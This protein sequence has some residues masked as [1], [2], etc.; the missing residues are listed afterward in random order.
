MIE[1]I[2]VKNDAGLELTVTDFYP[3]Y[4]EAISGGISTNPTWEEYLDSINEEYRPH[5]NLIKKSFEDLGWVGEK[6]RYKSNKTCFVFSDGISFGFSWR[7]W[8]DLMSA[9]VG[10]RE[11]YMYYYV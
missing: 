1:F 6:A 7:A 9:I 3:E 5:I 2:K 11:G 4:F 10:Q 8:G